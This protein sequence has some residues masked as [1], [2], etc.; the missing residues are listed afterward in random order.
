MKLSGR[1]QEAIASATDAV[2]FGICGLIALLP[3]WTWSATCRGIA[4][5]TPGRSRPGRYE[6]R[7]RLLR[8]A[9]PLYG[10]ATTRL[11]GASHLDE[12]LRRGCGAILWVA[13]GNDSDLVTKKALAEAG[14]RAAH[15]SRP[16]HGFF[17]SSIGQRLFNPIQ[18][19]VEDRYLG[20]R[21][22]LSDDNGPGALR[23]LLRRLAANEVVS[24]RIG[25][26]S[27]SSRPLE[28]DGRRLP[29]ATGPLRL[30]QRS[31]AALLPVVSVAEGPNAFVTRVGPD[32]RSP[33]TTEL[34]STLPD[35]LASG[36]RLEG[37]PRTPSRRRRAR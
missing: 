21:L 26:A 29:I 12:A 4:A 20:E 24:I 32:I 35:Y 1:A 34:E 3:A 27:R 25:G 13:Q 6:Q 31:G 2:V 15:L 18:R 8:E 14:F 28:V 7:V 30:A 10:G 5:I 37:W 23:A 17:R 33:A 9:L 22:M 16:S 19:H 11:E 36:R